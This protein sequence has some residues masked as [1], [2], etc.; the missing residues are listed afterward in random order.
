ML[1]SAAPIV[2]R[3]VRFGCLDGCMYVCVCGCEGDFGAMRA[4]WVSDLRWGFF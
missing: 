4:C 3:G 2:E 1:F